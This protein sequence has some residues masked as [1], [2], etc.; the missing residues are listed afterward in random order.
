M[1]LMLAELKWMKNVK[2]FI[3]VVFKG[4]C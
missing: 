2:V 4:D 1:R 3:I